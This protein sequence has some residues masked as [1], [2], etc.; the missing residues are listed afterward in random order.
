M[1]HEG[2]VLQEEPPRTAF[3]GIEQP[4]NVSDE[5]GVATSNPSRSS[6]LAEILAWKTG[7]H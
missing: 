4:E 5:A 2:H 6:S 3:P 1:E 7:G